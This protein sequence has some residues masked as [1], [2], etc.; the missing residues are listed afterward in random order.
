VAPERKDMKKLLIILLFFTLCL[1]SIILTSE[2]RMSVA[3]SNGTV[4]IDAEEVTVNNLEDI[5]EYLVGIKP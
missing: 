3:A 5:E 4:T 1:G 2:S